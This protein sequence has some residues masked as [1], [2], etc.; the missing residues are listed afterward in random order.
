M[1]PNVFDSPVGELT[2]YANEKGLVAIDWPTQSRD[3]Q[4]E[5]KSSA[6]HSLV[7]QARSELDAYFAGR[8]TRFS[9]PV[10]PEGTDFQQQVWQ[11][12][13]AIPYGET[14]TYGQLAIDLG[15]PNG[16]RAVG[17]ATG[18][19]PIPI[20]IPCHRLLGSNGKLTGFAGGLPAKQQ[21]L[22]LESRDNW[23]GR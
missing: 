8:L 15:Q 2:I 10:D 4:P 7:E 1:R 9:T 23:W 13:C 11:A 3:V 17:A 19:N 14:S 12:L 6:A 18:R 16:S 22:A 5:S 21:L 20:I